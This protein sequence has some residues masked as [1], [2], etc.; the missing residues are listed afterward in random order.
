V[1]HDPRVPLEPAHRAVG[2]GDAV[3]GPDD[4]LT[5]F[6]ARSS[7]G[8]GLAEPPGWRPAHPAC[9]HSRE[10][11]KR[12]ADLA[13]LSWSRLDPDL[14]SAD[15]ESRA[16]WKRVCPYRRMTTGVPS[17]TLRIR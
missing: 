7:L 6:A 16:R 10:E 11:D 14:H 1:R 17:G 8:V 13:G 15:R 4:L 5:F 2:A 3:L 12:S 9:S